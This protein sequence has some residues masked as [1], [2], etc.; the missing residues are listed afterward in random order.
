MAT[1]EDYRSTLRSM[2]I[3]LED[4]GY[5][6][7]DFADDELNIHLDAALARL[8][9]VV[10][11]KMAVSS[12][13]VTSYGERDLGYA[14]ISIPEDRVFMVE[15]ASEF[16]P[17][18]GWATRPGKVIGLD[19]ELSSV[20]I[21]Y[22]APFTMPDDDVTELELP[23]EYKVL[24]TT[25]SMLEAVASRYEVGRQPGPVEN[26]IGGEGGLM[27]RLIRRYETLKNEMEMSLPAVVNG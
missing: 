22:F 27:D 11:R 9:P 21:Y 1:R 12:V 19:D 15:D 16:E 2:L 23:D 24:V 6:N 18:R 4:A 5:G 20:N 3:G 26:P 25:G 17:I 13:S 8:F 10:Y 14:A 7:M